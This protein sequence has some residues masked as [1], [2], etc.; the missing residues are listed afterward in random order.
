METLVQRTMTTTTLKINNVAGDEGN[1]HEKVDSKG[2]VT[3]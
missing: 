2:N 1:L 3:T